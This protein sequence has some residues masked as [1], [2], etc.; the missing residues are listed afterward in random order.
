MLP[1]YDDIKDAAKP[2]E[3]IWYT[4]EGVP[5][6]RAFTPSMMGIYDRYVVYYEIAC[7][8]C[9]VKFNVAEG[10]SSRV[11]T[12]PACFSKKII[13]NLHFGDPPSHNC[14]GDTMNCYDLQ[15]LEFWRR[16]PWEWT[17]NPGLEIKLVDYEEGNSV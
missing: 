15:V 1:A 12:G 11:A 13:P 9:F 5:R 17:R 7:Q 16:E 3:P 6:Y 10:W 8:S 14:V 2:L 4:A